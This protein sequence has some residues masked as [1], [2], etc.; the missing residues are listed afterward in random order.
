MTGLDTSVV[1]RLLIGEPADQAERA[2]ALLDELFT[3][4]EQATVSDLV[5]SEVYFALQHHYG[6]PKKEAIAALRAL[7]ENGEVT[8]T[9]A[10]PK[11]LSEPRLASAKPGLIDRL[12]HQGYL[13]QDHNLATFEKQGRK[14]E[15]TRVL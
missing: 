12:I 8:G 1:V 7:F 4:G 5:V 14:L 10:A 6:V 11:V 15:R 3:Q 9:G 2:K 13:A